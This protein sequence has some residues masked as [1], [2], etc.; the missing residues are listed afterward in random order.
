MKK[1]YTFLILFS[2]SIFLALGVLRSN[3]YVGATEKDGGAG[4]NC[5]SLSPFNQVSAWVQGPDSVL[6]GTTA[7]Y[8]LYMTGGPKI[9]GGFNLA[10]LRGKLSSVDG[11]TKLMQY[12]VGDTQLTH[13]SPLNFSNKDTISWSFS[14][15]APSI[16]GFDTI[17][18]VVNSTNGNG[19][20]DGN[21]RWNFGQKFVI[22]VHNTPVKVENENLLVSD[23]KLYQNYPNPFSATG[24]SVYGGNPGTTISWQLAVGSWQT[25]KLY[26]SN[27]EEIETIVDGYFDAGF[28]STFYILH[29]TLP[30]GVYFYQ[31]RAGNYIE[32]KKMV[33]IR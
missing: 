29:S 32:T 31:L 15:R 26:N 9:R 3:G 12:V 17:Y 33:L 30:S 27:G 2:S 18:S 23:F 8:K 22:K 13:S 11:L 7:N 14:Y 28:H 6:V 25:I 4:C 19:I 1:F 20:A 24:S 21:D 5:H 10:A 16:I